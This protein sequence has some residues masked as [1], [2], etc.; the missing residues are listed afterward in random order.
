MLDDYSCVMC[1]LQL[2][3]RDHMLSNAFL[4]HYAGIIYA[5]HGLCWTEARWIFRRLF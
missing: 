2:E 1:G 3:T 5:L 4:P